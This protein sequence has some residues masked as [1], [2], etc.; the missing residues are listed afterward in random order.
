M[1]RNR[2]TAGILGIFGLLIFLTGCRDSSPVADSEITGATPANPT[3]Q[4]ATKG[5][6]RIVSGSENKTLASIIERWGR[7][8]NVAVEMEYKGSVDIMLALQNPEP[9]PYDAVWPAN[10]LWIAL[11]DNQKRIKDEQSIF[12]SP[13]ALG[14]K[15][16][17]AQKLG[18]VGKPVKVE[19]ILKAAENGSFKFMMTSATQSNSGASA[20]LGFLYAFA[21][22]PQALSAADLQKPEVES[23]IKRIL[24]SVDRSAGSSG[25]LKDLFIQKYAIYD[26]MFNYEAVLIE[27]NQ[28]LLKEGKE[29]LYLIY[30]SDGLALADSPLAFV[31]NGSSERA[32]KRELVQSLQKYLLSDAVQKEILA[33]GR[34]IGP[35]GDKI[36][37]MDMTVFNPDWGIK[38]DAF[39]NQ[40][41]YPK[42]D[43]IRQA[44]N[45]Y[46][47]AFRKPSLTIY[48]LDYS[49]SMKGERIESLKAAMKRILDQTEA[50]KSFL[51]ASARDV[52]IVIPF[53]NRILDE[54]TVE[55]ND[56]TALEEIYQKIDNLQPDGGTDIYSPTLRALEIL[57]QKSAK[58][59]EF[60]PAVILL[61]DGESNTGRTIDDLRTVYQSGDFGENAPVFGI[62]FGEASQSQLK[63]VSEL[64][65]GRTFD[66]RKDLTT[67]F[68]D[69]KGY[70]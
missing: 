37:G 38:N 70:N 22:S 48:C 53:S 34:R 15:K 19:D 27:T 12:W 29:P 63:A 65:S 9:F 64:T 57:N 52:T 1:L 32:R 11:G 54:W 58:S 21:G 23:K 47:S 39:L 28:E 6:L 36:T 31:D 62:Q 30:P 61:T 7:E 68:R 43:V 25:W 60:F 2:K 67:A 3:V 20:Y 4:I 55:G 14:V 5:T 18:W 56:P 10:S 41:R 66:G 46:Q 50:K 69:A 16:S 13:V 59:G 42:A 26:A 49:G 40:I 51:Q 8:N 17:I 24:G 45:L 44:L 33:Q 35:V